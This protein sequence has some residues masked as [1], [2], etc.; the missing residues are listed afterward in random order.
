MK[1]LVLKERKGS[2]REVFTLTLKG[3]VKWLKARSQ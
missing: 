3:A 1:N 2:C